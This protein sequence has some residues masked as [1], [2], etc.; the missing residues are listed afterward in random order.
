MSDN[1]ATLPEGYAL[2]GGNNEIVTVASEK[3][4]VEGVDSKNYEL[5]ETEAP[6]GFNKIDSRIAITILTDNTLIKEVE[7]FS[8]SVLPST[9]GIG[10]TIFYILGGILIVAGVAYFIVRRKASAE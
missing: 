7:N 4:T 10:T 8:G 9:G 2:V 1:G 3:I 5:L 6:L